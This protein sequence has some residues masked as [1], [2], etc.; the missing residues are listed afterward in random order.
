MRGLFKRNEE[1]L[2]LLL[3]ALDAKGRGSFIQ[4]GGTGTSTILM[5]LVARRPNDRFLI[6][7][8]RKRS[9]TRLVENWKEAGIGL[10]A[11]SRVSLTTYHDV[12]NT[13]CPASGYGTIVLD[14]F[15]LAGAPKVSSG[16]ERLFSQNP[17]ARRVGCGTTRFRDTDGRDMAF[18]LFGAEP[19][20][21]RDLVDAWKAGDLARPLY[22]GAL[23]STPRGLI[24]LDTW[25]SSTDPRFKKEYDEEYEEIRRLIDQ[26]GNSDEVV[27]RYLKPYPNARVVVF[28]PTI[29]RARSQSAD[30]RKVFGKV[31]REVHAY[32]FHSSL[33]NPWAN[34]ASFEKDDSS[35]LKVLYCVDMLTEDIRL[36]GVRAVVMT[37]P[38]KSNAVFLSQIG[39]AIS[40]K[41]LGKDKTAIIL[42]LVNNITD[43]SFAPNRQSRLGDGLLGAKIREQM[44]LEAGCEVIDMLGDPAGILERV[45]SLE[46]KYTQ[47]R[48]SLV[49]TDDASPVVCHETGELFVGFME[50]ADW[51]SREN[52]RTV[53]PSQIRQATRTGG[54]AGG[55]HWR[56]PGEALRENQD[57]PIEDVGLPD[58]TFVPSLPKSRKKRT[59]AADDRELLT[60]FGLDPRDF[61]VEG[62]YGDRVYRLRDGK[63]FTSVGAAAVAMGASPAQIQRAIR[64]R[65]PIYNSRLFYYHGE[66]APEPP[67]LSTES[68]RP[69]TRDTAR[70]E[71]L[72]T[73]EHKA[74]PVR[75]HD[76]RG[77]DVSQTDR[78]D[79]AG[80]CDREKEMVT[81][82]RVDPS[83]MYYRT[84]QD[85]CSALGFSKTTVKRA[86]EEGQPVGA[87]ELC[88]INCPPGKAEKLLEKASARRFVPADGGRKTS[89]GTGINKDE[90]PVTEKRQP[91]RRN[92]K[93]PVSQAIADITGKD[94]KLDTD[95]LAMGVM[96]LESGAEYPNLMIAAMRTGTSLEALTES[97]RL[98]EPVDG[99][100]WVLL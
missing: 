33:A 12:A 73:L 9:R 4:P 59:T 69:K 43:D 29:E 81:L 6:I 60:N 10:E 18:E 44:F 66:P 74:S 94:G 63:V 1:T 23:Y 2:L 16:L 76:G 87:C 20:V 99:K 39:R 31:N 78:V 68:R 51:A 41:G 37:R 24:G 47:F 70:I 25:W 82:I 67:N 53:K 13:M 49:Q 79:V 7:C 75:A 50:A 48:H 72:R 56:L 15:T 90:A 93:K 86:L 21:E 17:N 91:A 89:V 55:F 96:C 57:R 83:G 64:G 19:V 84:V 40:S 28:C 77:P 27:A 97:I 85:V 92:T 88:Y 34:L 42:D 52:G 80:N 30:S 22:V 58:D 3:E 5:H 98:G 61:R 65:K 46:D 14:D 71:R 62:D 38:T 11:L 100:T 26:I 35:A 45:R 95:F 36:D 54:R 32:E 8:A